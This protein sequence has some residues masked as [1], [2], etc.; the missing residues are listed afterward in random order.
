MKAGH[1]FTIEPMINEGT[2]HDEMWPDNWTV[3]TKGMCVCVC[4]GGGGW[5][6]NK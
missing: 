5:V 6:K 4:G 2:W 3:T 1:T